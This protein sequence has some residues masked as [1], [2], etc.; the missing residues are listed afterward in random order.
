MI[1]K[2]QSA[3]SLKTVLNSI[4]ALGLDGEH[5]CYLIARVR[6]GFAVHCSVRVRCGCDQCV[7]M[8]FCGGGSLAS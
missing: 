2:P 3:A 1:Y 7:H 5:M 8:Y 4:I 6:I